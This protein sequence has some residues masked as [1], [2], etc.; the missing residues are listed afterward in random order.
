M[1]SMKQSQTLVTTMEGDSMIFGVLQK[2][3]KGKYDVTWTRKM[4]NPQAT[5]ENMPSNAG[6]QK[7]LMRQTK[8]WEKGIISHLGIHFR[9][10]INTYV[11]Y[12]INFN[13]FDMI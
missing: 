8:H 2:A 7:W 9:N 5:Y 3:V 11:K 6:D 4:P 10:H 12:I 1:H 13:I